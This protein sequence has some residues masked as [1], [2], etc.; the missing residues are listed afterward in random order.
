MKINRDKLIDKLAD[1]ITDAADW[2]AL[3]DYFRE[4][5]YDYLNTMSDDDLTEYAKNFIS[6]DEG[7]EIDLIE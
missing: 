6:L 7:E 3:C 5:Q 2:D 1:Q 4:G